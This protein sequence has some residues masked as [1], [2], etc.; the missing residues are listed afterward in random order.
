MQNGQSSIYELFNADRIFKIPNYQRTY[1]WQEENLKDFL[2]DLV[3]QRGNKSYFLGTFLFHNQNR[4]GDYEILD[5]VDGQQRLTTIIIF[6][7]VLI[8][9]LLELSSDKVSNKTYRRFVKDSDGVYKLE[10]DNE[11]NNFLNTYILENNKADTFETPAQKNLIQAKQY[12]KKEIEN[13][14][15]TSLEKIFDLISY[16]Y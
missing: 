8:E 11:D 12:L 6:A 2:D 1:T 5:I 10:L 15:K 13:I 14:S 16:Y 3:N 7:K 9:R 4:R